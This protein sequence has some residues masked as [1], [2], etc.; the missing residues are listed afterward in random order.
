MSVAAAWRE[1]AERQPLRFIDRELFA[2]LVESQ[3]AVS[4]WVGAASPEELV[5]LPNATTGLNAVI[6]SIV[7]ETLADGD[8]VLYLDVGYGSVQSMIERACRRS[9]A[10]PVA[11]PVSAHLPASVCPDA[12]VELVAA[13]ISPRTRLAVFDDITSNHA[14]ALPVAQLCSLCEER[15]V[16]SVVDAAHG[17]GSRAR[18]QLPYLSAEGAGG[19]RPTFCVGNLHKWGNAPRGAAFLWVGQAAHRR[20]IEP[21]VVSHGYGGGFASS[22]IWSG[23]MDYSALL[24]LPAVIDWWGADGMPASI[25]YQQR[26]LADTVQLLG[27][28]WG[29]RAL[30]APS[31]GNN[32]ALV[33]LPT[34]RAVPGHE[35]G[36]LTGKLV[37]D[38]LHFAHRLE[39]PVKTLRGALYV[40]I[41]AAVYNSKEDFV[42]LANAVDAMR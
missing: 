37:Q 30:V 27:E 19:A 6:G 14:L 24:A 28:A 13:S 31:D 29:T 2:H 21:P 12:L 10:R 38:A 40:R 5:L 1:H 32:M 15:G 23:A 8:E 22:F 41:S 7:G 26:L 36:P 34:L 35:N 42:H 33:R 16:L 3:R 18:A 25:G 4:Q 17:V 9:G 11:V 39:C 20:L